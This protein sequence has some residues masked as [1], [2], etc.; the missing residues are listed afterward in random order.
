MWKSVTKV[1]IREHKFHL[2]LADKLNTEQIYFIVWSERYFNEKG[3][4][5]NIFIS[6]I[7]VRKARVWL[8][9][10]NTCAHETAADESM[11]FLKC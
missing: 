8:S 4:A 2:H 10:L 1:S 7:Y 11:G 3:I 9:W 5:S 6:Q